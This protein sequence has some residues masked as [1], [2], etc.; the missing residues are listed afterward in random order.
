MNQCYIWLRKVGLNS[1][2][3]LD[4]GA[5]WGQRKKYMIY[6]IVRKYNTDYNEM[7]SKA[8]AGKF[9]LIQPN[10]F[11]FMTHVTTA[12]LSILGGIKKRWRTNETCYGGQA[13][14]RWPQVITN[15]PSLYKIF[16]RFVYLKTKP[17]DMSTAGIS[18]FKYPRRKLILE[19]A[20]KDI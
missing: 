13:R 5:F 20:E 1:R 9:K 14:N 8:L 19:K 11:S 16:I 12:F 18:D 2:C 15:G 7:F 17:Y 10:T 6:M 3:G 4:V